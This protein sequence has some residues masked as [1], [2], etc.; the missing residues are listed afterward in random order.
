MKALTQRQAVRRATN[1]SGRVQNFTEQDFMV[2]E[3]DVGHSKPHYL[4]FQHASYTFLTK[5]LGR[6][7]RESR[8]GAEYI[9]WWFHSKGN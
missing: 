1:C 2:M 7:V 5:D 3:E 4:G 6:L 8:Q 9:C